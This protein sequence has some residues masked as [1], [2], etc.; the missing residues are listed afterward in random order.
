MKRNFNIIIALFLSMLVISSCKKDDFTYPA[1]FVGSS[2]IT[3]YATLTFK[4]DQYTLIPQGGTYSEVGITATEAGTPIEY[5][6]EGTVNTAVPG[7]YPIYY[8]A[9][10]K[11]GFPS[12]IIRTVVVYNTDASATAHDLSG[13]YVRI[14][15]GTP[16]VIAT[17]KK[18]GPG[19]YKVV[20]PGGAAGSTLTVIAFN[21]TG[22]K[23]LIPKQISSDGLETS[24]STEDFSGMPTTYKWVILNPGY[25]TGLR[26]FQK[27]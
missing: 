21:P 10:N 22:Y 7:V 2:Q 16:P 3:Y 9:I 8:S 14:P 19:V 11:D 12:S 20:N 26:T 6:T 27:L 15:K 1:G 24:S 17:W 13:D 18:L 4:G 25:G 5:T 23:I